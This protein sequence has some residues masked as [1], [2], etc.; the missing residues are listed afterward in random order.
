[1]PRTGARLSIALASS[2]LL[3]ACSPASTMPSAPSIGT[4][5]PGGN[6]PQ[7]NGPA[8]IPGVPGF[9]LS[10]HIVEGTPAGPRPL[11][12]GHV[13]YVVEE[14]DGGIAAIAGHVG[15]D[16]NGRYAI[17]NIP[18]GR[19]VRVTGFMAPTPVWMSQRSPTSA[20]VNADT[21]LDIELV[22]PGFRGI[23][24]GSPTLTGLAFEMTPEGRRPVSNTPVVY[25]TTYF[26][27]FAAYT[28]TDSSGHFEFDRVQLGAGLLAAGDCNDSMQ[29][30]PIQINGDKVVDVDL[31]AMIANCP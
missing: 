29:S 16:L 13:D 1:M 4:L 26:G 23:S 18:A 20:I 7:P 31:T 3:A 5:P 2:A 10:G 12:G 30:A 14:A 21:E 6:N 28:H 9:T 15:A 19:R 11:P 17:A 25:Y 22:A 8:P 27:T 24:P